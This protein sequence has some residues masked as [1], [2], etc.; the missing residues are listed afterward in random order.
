MSKQD[1]LLMLHGQLLAGDRR[2][3]SKIVELTIAPLVAIVARDVAGLYDRQ[4]VEQTCFDALLKYLANPGAYS[5]QRGAL[6]TYLAAIAKGKARTLRRSQTRRTTH[7]GAYAARGNPEEGDPLAL[8][9]NEDSMLR[10]I[11]WA[12]FGDDLVKDP[13]DAVIVSL[14]K[15]GESA[16]SVYAE[17]LGLAADDDG[18]G[19]AG[20]RVERIR[21][22]ARRI[23]EKM[24]A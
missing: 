24:D 21:G 5:P 2:A 18:L 9:Q 1:D 15:A 19:E 16:L 20:R 7:E 17:A 8:V 14:M 6:M 12:K 3:A 4:D 11:D 23:E 22:R 10:Q 13:G